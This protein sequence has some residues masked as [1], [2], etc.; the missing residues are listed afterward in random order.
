MRFLVSI[1]LVVALL[2][3]VWV[4]R[5][6]DTPGGETELAEPVFGPV[7]G[8]DLAPSD[9]E[10]VAVGT[11]APDFTLMAYSRDPVTLSDFRGEKDVI[12]VFYRG[13]W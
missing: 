13:H 12:L 4:L 3:G 10:R 8:F 1:L 9:I 11:T 6:S 7:D 5:T 2:A